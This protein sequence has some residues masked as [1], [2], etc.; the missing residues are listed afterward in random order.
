[1]AS[2][3]PGDPAP[4][5][6]DTDRDAD[7]RFARI[8]LA[9]PDW[10]FRLLGAGFFLSYLTL[11]ARRYADGFWNL[12][13]YIVLEDGRRLSMPWG[14]VLIDLTYLIIALGFILR[15]PPQRR[16]SD[17]RDILP[18]MWGTF[19]PF[20][21]FFGLWLAELFDPE[22]ARRF[23]RFMFD[24][25]TWTPASFALASGLIVAGNA[26]DVWGYGRLLRSI[27]IVPEARSLQVNGPYRF[28]RHPIYLGQMLAQAGVWLVFARWHVVWIGFYA[29]FVILQ[30][31]RAYREEAVLTQAFGD[32]YR[33]WTRRTFWFG[34]N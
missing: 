8:W 7:G 26:L 5:T 21:P 16:A 18:A 9:L 28:V 31:Y 2:R 6:T 14:Q 17:W 27:S 25:S 32:T 3:E 1:M 23:E 29:V 11:R 33:D 24:Y 30:F 15:A 19:W 22:A 12:G 10:T 4:N 13:P 34:L 20:L